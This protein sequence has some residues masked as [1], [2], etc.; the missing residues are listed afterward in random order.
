MA[1]SVAQYCPQELISRCDLTIEV[2]L[3]L[4]SQLSLSRAFASRVSVVDSYIKK[5]SGFRVCV[6]VCMCMCMC[7]CVCVSVYVYVH[8]HVYVCV[9]VYVR[10]CAYVCVVCVGGRE[11][12]GGYMHGYNYW[13][14]FVLVLCFFLLSFHESLF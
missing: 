8:V 9:S 6:C 14:I 11:G 12:G 10:V 2:S 5:Q 1:Q 13:Q 7:M 3:R 4:S